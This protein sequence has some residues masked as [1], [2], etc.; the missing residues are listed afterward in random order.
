MSSIAKAI[1][2]GGVNCYLL[3]AGNGYILID[4]GF[5]GKRMQ[6]ENVLQNAGCKPGMLK[7]IILT[8]GDSDHADNCAYLRRKYGS[9]IAMHSLDSG[10]VEQGDM[11]WNRKEKADKYSMIFRVLGFI[12]K[13]FS[14]GDKF[15]KFKPDILIDEGFDLTKYGL[16]AKVLHIPGHSKGSIG[17]LT[18]EGELICG[19][20]VYN[21]PGF[22]FIDDMADHRKSME[23]LKQFKINTIYPGH[24][25]PFPMSKLL[26]R[27]Y[28]LEK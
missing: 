20:F 8:H 17:V 25:K 24:G 21:M 15:E 18:E 22:Q 10:M 16:R 19:D 27:E 11:S 6:L 12:T 28:I 7:L 3:F 23:K 14:G 1:Y 2:L 26:K 4:T 13:A 5:I 9:Q